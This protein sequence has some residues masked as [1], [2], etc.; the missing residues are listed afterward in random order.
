MD[1]RIAASRVLFQAADEL[2]IDL[3]VIDGQL[4]QIAEGRGAGAEII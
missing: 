3:D 2:P 1:L 4:L